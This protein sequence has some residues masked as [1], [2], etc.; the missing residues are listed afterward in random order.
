MPRIARVRTDH[1]GRFGLVRGG[2]EPP[3]W[4]ELVDKVPPGVWLG[5]GAT[6]ISSAVMKVEEF[7]GPDFPFRCKG[8]ARALRAPT[9]QS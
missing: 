5:G 9:S 1:V 7:F 2:S 8:E 6:A 4:L 3:R